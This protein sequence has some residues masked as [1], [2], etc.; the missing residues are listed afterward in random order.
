MAMYGGDII[1][2][3]NV[4]R[5]I[6]PYLELG[7]GYLN[8]YDSYQGEDVL[9]PRQTSGYFAKGGVGLAVPISKNFE[10]F[11]SASLMYTSQRDNNDLENIISPNELTQHSVYNAGIRFQI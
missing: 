6:V 5:G 9:L 10:I 1:A 7:G 2:K 4:A 11:G 3:L 8:I